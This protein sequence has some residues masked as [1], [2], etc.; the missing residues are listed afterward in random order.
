VL[1]EALFGH[2]LRGVADRR[3]KRLARNSCRSDSSLKT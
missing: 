2:A 1:L 3:R